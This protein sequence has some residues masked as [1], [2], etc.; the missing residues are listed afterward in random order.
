MIFK[1][2]RAINMNQKMIDIFIVKGKNIFP[3]PKEKEKKS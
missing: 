2:I 1:Y 3:Q